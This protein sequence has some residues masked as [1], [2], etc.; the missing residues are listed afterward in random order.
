M[1]I[2]YHAKEGQDKWVLHELDQKENGYFVDIGAH[3]GFHDSN[4]YTLEKEFGWTGICV[5]P[6]NYS[7]NELVEHRSCICC[8]LC[9]F[10]E[11]KVIEFMQRGRHK[12]LSGIVCENS[13]DHIKS[14][15][16][17]PLMLKNAI[18]LMQLLKMHNAPKFIDYLNIDV[19]GVEWDIL[20]DFDFKQYVFRTMTIEHNCME[21]TEYPQEYVDKRNNILEL[22]E[23]KGYKR[24]RT[25]VADDWYIYNGD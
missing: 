20:K 8:N 18:T 25:V 22:L 1:G 5:E 12:Q 10:S 3:N 6:H 21:G 4:T 17:H 11:N 24:E 14:K 19:E 2:K 13:S 9:I 15:E 23:S 16:G 7:F